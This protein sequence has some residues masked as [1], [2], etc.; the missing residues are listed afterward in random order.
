[1]R[2]SGKAAEE[3]RGN[4]G[5]SQRATRGRPFARG[6]SGNPKGRPKGDFAKMVREALD[7][8]QTLLGFWLRVMADDN[9]NM[10][11]RM[12]ASALLDARGWGKPTQPLEHGGT[13]GGPLVVEVVRY[14]GQ[15]GGA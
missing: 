5:G 12:Q 4:S 11:F 7:N 14:D 9:E 3:Q 15:E 1:M 10:K 13:D 8:G 2:N 6:Q